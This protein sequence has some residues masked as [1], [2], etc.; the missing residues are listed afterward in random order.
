[1]RRKRLKIPGEEKKHTNVPLTSTIT[2]YIKTFSLNEKET[3][4]DPTRKEQAHNVPST[5]KDQTFKSRPS[6]STRRKHLT[7]VREENKH[8]KT[9]PQPQ[10]PNFQVKDQNFE[11]KNQSLKTKIESKD[12]TFVH[13]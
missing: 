7:V 3:F 6:L 13:L 10:R 2:F 8:T 1:M 11:I 4:E 12:V 9:W 5:P